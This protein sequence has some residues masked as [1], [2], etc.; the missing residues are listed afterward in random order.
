MYPHTLCSGASKS[1]GLL[2]CWLALDRSRSPLYFL[3]PSD[4]TFPL[5][6]CTPLSTSLLHL[7]S[8]WEL[9]AW[10]DEVTRVAGR[11]VFQ[12]ILVLRLSPPKG[13]RWSHLSHHRSGPET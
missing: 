4:R 3:R 7:G 5:A 13:T 12:V 9:P 11:I 8:G 1:K 10:A 6:V 2:R